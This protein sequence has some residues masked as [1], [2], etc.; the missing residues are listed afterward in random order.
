MTLTCPTRCDAFAPQ[1]TARRNRLPSLKKSRFGFT[2]HDILL[3]LTLIGDPDRFPR[4]KNS[5]KV[6]NIR[7]RRPHHRFL[8]SRAKTRRN[9]RTVTTS[10]LLWPNEPR[11]AAFLLPFWRPNS[12]VLRSDC[13]RVG[14]GLAI[15]DRL[16]LTGVEGV[17]AEEATPILPIAQHPQKILTKSGSRC[18]RGRTGEQR[19]S[20]KFCPKGD[21]CISLLWK[22]YA[23]AA[24]NLL[25]E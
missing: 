24:P 1:V 25:S 3:L 13:K 7:R 10:H 18:V 11:R 12:N 6:G 4:R 21:P 9:A 17:K 14:C 8:P 16:C 22:K 23:A 2:N 15:R 5:S 19:L 20:Y